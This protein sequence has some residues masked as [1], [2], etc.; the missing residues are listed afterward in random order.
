MPTTKIN[1]IIGYEI[2]RRIDRFY[3]S[4]ALRNHFPLKSLSFEVD[5]P[6]MITYLKSGYKAYLKYGKQKDAHTI[7]DCLAYANYHN[8]NVSPK[9]TEHGGDFEEK[10][11]SSV[12]DSINRR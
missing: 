9:V 11:H 7:S 3:G 1:N 2:A 4:F 5:N 8:W 12:L 10:F 6:E